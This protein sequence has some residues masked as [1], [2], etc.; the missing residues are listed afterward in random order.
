MA[1]EPH[2]GKRNEPALVTHVAEA[3]ARQRSEAL[4]HVQEYTTANA[5]RFFRLEPDGS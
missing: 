4:E 3:V 2:R 1:P 5:L